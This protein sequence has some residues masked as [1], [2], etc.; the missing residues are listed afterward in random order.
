LSR[1]AWA[2]LAGAAGRV[3]VGRGVVG[4]VGKATALVFVVVVL[5]KWVVALAVAEAAAVIAAGAVVETAVAAVVPLADLVALV[6]VDLVALAG[7]AQGEVP[8]LFVVRSRR[9]T[10][11]RWDG[12]PRCTHRTPIPRSWA[13]G[14]IHTLRIPTLWIC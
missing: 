3:V 12:W 14:W 13:G 7:I 10:L 8:H 9:Y 6:V 11:W 5:A 4:V 1:V 2:Y